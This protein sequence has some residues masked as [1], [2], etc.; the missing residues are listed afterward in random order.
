MSQPDPDAFDFNIRDLR[1]IARAISL[2]QHRKFNNTSALLAVFTE[3][4]DDSFAN[5]YVELVRNAPAGQFKELCEYTESIFNVVAPTFNQYLRDAVGRNELVLPYWSEV[6]TP[7]REINEIS[8]FPG[9]SK[10][11]MAFVKLLDECPDECE[12]FLSGEA[13]MTLQ[14]V[15]GVL[16][17][18]LKRGGYD[19][20]TPE[21]FALFGFT[22]DTPTQ[23]ADDHPKESVEAESEPVNEVPGADG[24]ES[25]VFEPPVR[26]QSATVVQQEYV[27]DVEL[28]REEYVPDVAPTREEYVPNT[29]PTREEYVSDSET[30]SIQSGSNNGASPQMPECLNFS[31][32][33]RV[34]ASS[35][36][37]YPDDVDTTV[38]AVPEER[39]VEAP[40]PETVSN[41]TEPLPEVPIP[42]NNVYTQEHPTIS[43]YDGDTE[44][45]SGTEVPS[46]DVD[47]IN[48]NDVAI[49]PLPQ[50]RPVLG[51][52]STTETE[53]DYGDVL[54]AAIDDLVA[55]K[56]DSDKILLIG[57]KMTQNFVTS[58]KDFE[59]LITVIDKVSAD[60]YVADAVLFLTKQVFFHLPS[61]NEGLL[62]FWKIVAEKENPL[63]KVLFDVDGYL[64]KVVLTGGASG[65][66]AL[67]RAKNFA[68]LI[69]GDTSTTLKHVVQKA[70]I[71]GASSKN[72]WARLLQKVTAAGEFKWNK[73]SIMLNILQEEVKTG[74]KIE[75]LT[76]CNILKGLSATVPPILTGDELLLELMRHVTKPDSPITWL[77]ALTS[78]VTSLRDGK[79]TVQWTGETAG[80]DNP[81]ITIGAL[82]RL[83]NRTRPTGYNAALLPIL[84]KLTHILE[85]SD[86]VVTLRDELFY[87]NS[88]WSF[89]FCAVEP[90][91]DLIPR[92]HQEVPL[93]VFNVIPEEKRGSY[94][95]IRGDNEVS[96]EKYLR[97]VL[98]VLAIHDEIPDA[99]VENIYAVYTEVPDVQAQL[100]DAV[101]T[102]M[103]DVVSSMEINLAR[104]YFDNLLKLLPQDFGSALTFTGISKELMVDC[105]GLAIL[106]GAALRGIDEA[107]LA[108]KTRPSF[109]SLSGATQKLITLFCVLALPHV[110][111]DDQSPANGILPLPWLHNS[112]VTP[113]EYLEKNFVVTFIRTYANCFNRRIFHQIGQ[114]K[115]LLE[116]T[117]H[118]FKHNS[119]VHVHEFHDPH[120]FN[121][122]GGVR[123][124]GYASG[125][126][127]GGGHFN[128]SGN[129][130]GGQGGDGGHHAG[131][132]HLGRG[133]GQVGA[134]GG[135]F[136]S[137][138]RSNGGEGGFNRSNGYGGDG[139]FNRNG[140]GGE[141]GFA[142]SGRGGYAPATRGYFPVRGGSNS[143]DSRGGGSNPP[144]T[145][146]SSNAIPVP[147]GVAQRKFVNGGGSKP[148][149]PNTFNDP[150]ASNSGRGGGRGGFN[151]S[152]PEGFNR[153]SEGNFP[154]SDVRYSQQN[155]GGGGGFLNVARNNP[156]GDADGNN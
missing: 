103:N 129:G 20:L 154:S 39:V 142:H 92:Y 140:H 27:P 2:D 33:P 17:D 36:E 80:Y 139:G 91:R 79:I 12:T 90:I 48:I 106:G 7:F 44:R 146:G 127:R 69:V 3:E 19:Y 59:A 68:W 100:I 8:D 58:L 47:V 1:I 121:S 102:S 105:Q 26:Q 54:T 76:Y 122:E 96:F 88:D 4:E 65:D 15:R 67:Y 130:F 66:E 123:N 147:P 25:E 89:K 37:T 14:K 155:G 97:F 52:T 29:E 84:Q 64:A 74:E 35:V 5:G 75:D 134:D 34:A 120:Y 56:F 85:A 57:K 101:Y 148:Y 55:E 82:V 83:F 60:E 109:T 150:G 118:Y 53:D 46:S 43:D 156:R 143:Y 72:E 81:A 137:F 16:L 145:H 18:V 113:Q 70:L 62:A 131:G 32:D 112:Q 94:R 138:N 153:S 6:L 133:N 107:T 30:T 21:F 61:F 42:P 11:I 9:T 63:T 116:Q 31:V 135:S 98:E 73:K 152:R 22:D 114:L 13:I 77:N 132:F 93:S 95:A 104:K 149:S 136:G 111:R 24:Q 108:A 110:K 49:T 28:T 144:F 125:G 51:S 23:H 119:A 87:E 38:E 78:W 71:S 40:I 41:T 115:T 99:F 128:G 151:N 126:S 45:P 50:M 86:V 117:I 10:V 124:N 141:N